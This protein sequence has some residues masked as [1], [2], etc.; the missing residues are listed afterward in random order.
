MWFWFAKA[1]SFLYGL[2]HD[3]LGFNLRGMG[4]FMRRIRTEHVLTV[5]GVKMLLNPAV[6]SCYIR[7]INGRFNEP[8][9]H[10]FL[11]RI[12]PL[13]DTPLL[14]VDVGANVGEM[15]VDAAQYPNVQHVIG[16]E[17]NP[18]CAKACLRSAAL[19]GF[20][21]IR[22]VQKVANADGQ[23]VT[24]NFSDVAPV[25]SSILAQENRHGELIEATTLDRE[26]KEYT[27]S[28]ILLIDVEGAEKLVMLGGKEFIEQ[29]LPLIIFE[30]ND[31]TRRFCTLEE[32]Q[33]VLGKEYII[34]RLRGDGFLDSL[35]T[36]TWNCVAVH[37]RS[38]LFSF[39]QNFQVR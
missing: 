36:K 20:T 5:E 38:S 39:C 6:A 18:E 29:N 37:R 28:A 26:L 12:I 23:P 13:F 30:F 35:L 19:N 11:R 31:L 17:P 22:I 16:I 8:E 21:K 14:V 32:I 15:L 33:N 25:S 7:N 2:C 4:F 9:T 24:F 3:Y 10:I 27:G 34:F 1:Y